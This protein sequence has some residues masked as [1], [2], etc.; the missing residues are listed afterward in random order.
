[1]G[2]IEDTQCSPPTTT[3]YEYSA[4][5]PQGTYAPGTQ[6][7]PTRSGAAWSRAADAGTTLRALQIFIAK[8]CPKEQTQVVLPV[9]DYN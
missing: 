1:M 3:S 9:L 6:T 7:Q 4:P 8:S 2:T 5:G